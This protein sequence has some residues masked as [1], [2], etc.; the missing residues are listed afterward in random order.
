MKIMSLIIWLV[1]LPE[2]TPRHSSMICLVVVQSLMPIES[3]QPYGRIYSNSVIVCRVPVVQSIVQILQNGISLTCIGMTRSG[4][5][6]VVWL[7]PA[8]RLHTQ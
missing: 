1:S 8:M 5:I 3:I 7:F 6:D 4:N 2:G